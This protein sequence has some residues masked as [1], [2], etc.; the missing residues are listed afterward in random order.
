M[1]RGHEQTKEFLKDEPVAVPLRSDLHPPQ[2]KGLIKSHPQHPHILPDAS[3]YRPDCTLDARVELLKW[4]KDQLL[5]LVDDLTETLDRERFYAWLQQRELRGSLWQCRREAFHHARLFLPAVFL[6]FLALAV[7]SKE[8]QEYIEYLEDRLYEINDKRGEGT[9]FFVLRATG[10]PNN[11]LS[12]CAGLEDEDD[13]EGGRELE[14][15]EDMEQKDTVVPT[16]DTAQPSSNT[17]EIIRR[18]RQAFALEAEASLIATDIDYLCAL[19]SISV[20]DSLKFVVTATC[21]FLEEVRMLRDWIDVAEFLDR[22]RS[23]FAHYVEGER[24]ERRLLDSIEVFCLANDRRIDHHRTIVEAL[25]NLGFLSAS[26]LGDWRTEEVEDNPV[27][28]I[29]SANNK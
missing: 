18:L 16:T 2:T 17:S 13:A 20:D 15:D 7:Q 12:D 23:L 14:G 22:Y 5:E 29:G 10:Y 9:P 21:E 24:N 27:A 11:A 1:G 28:R 25:F 8:R 26:V 4:E 19:H 3:H 6:A